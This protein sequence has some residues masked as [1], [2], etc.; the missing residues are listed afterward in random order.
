MMRR[1]IMLLLLILSLET[2]AQHVTDS[3]SVAETNEGKQVWGKS[4]DFDKKIVYLETGDSIAYVLACDTTKKGKL[5]DDEYLY[6]VNVN[7]MHVLWNRSLKRSVSS[8]SKGTQRGVLVLSKSKTT[9]LPYLTL[10]DKMTGA[11]VWTQ[12]LYPVY[13]NDSLDLVVGLD[14][15]G[16]AETYAYRL[17]DGELLWHKK[18]PMTKNIGWDKAVMVDSTHMVVVGDNINEID[19]ATGHMW[20]VKAKTGVHDTKGAMMLALTNVVSI[21]GAVGL[22]SPVATY[23][24]NLQ[25]Y[26]ITGLT[27]NILH[28]NDNLYVSDREHLFCLGT[29]SLQLRWQ[30]EFPDKEASTAT[31]LMRRGKVFMLNYGYGNSL[32]RGIVKCGKPFLSVFEAK[33]GK[34]EKTLP[35]Y[36]KKHVMSDGLITEKGVFLAGGDKAVYLSFQDSAFVIKDWDKKEMGALLYVCRRKLY[37]YHGK[38]PVLSLIQPTAETCPMISGKGSVSVLDEKLEVKDTF[39]PFEMFSVCF[40]EGDA[41]C[42][43]NQDDDTNFWLIHQDGS[44]LAKVKWKPWTIFKA[45]KKALV[46]YRS[47]IVSFTIPQK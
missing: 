26:T 8:I 16:S 14:K 25:P 45:D 24:Y 29:D 37:G 32:M 44:P 47:S 9:T 22:G 23:Y 10:M 43:Q 33:D 12:N 21:A 2:R 35:L 30:Y 1:F 28:E 13:V 31:L 4:L 18:I 20:T 7:Q 6:A 15:I 40:E 34:Q 46:G 38:A 27:S 5:T 3:I 19:M 42:L 39:E 41:V 17:H 11:S 36:D